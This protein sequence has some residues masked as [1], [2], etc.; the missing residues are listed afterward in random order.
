MSLGAAARE[1]FEQRGRV[2]HNADVALLPLKVK[3]ATHLPTPNCNRMNLQRHQTVPTTLMALRLKS[4]LK[5]IRT[6][7]PQLNI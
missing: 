6:R 1:D 2:I 5:G 4:L 7:H 3:G